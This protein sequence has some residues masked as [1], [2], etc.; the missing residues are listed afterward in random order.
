VALVDYTI[1]T[2]MIPALKSEIRNNSDHIDDPISQ[3]FIKKVI[4]TMVGGPYNATYGSATQFIIQAMQEVA[5]SGVSV[6]TSLESLT[7]NIKI[8]YGVE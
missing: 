5:V 3:A 2:G 7:K 1:A 4:P 6:K 8:L